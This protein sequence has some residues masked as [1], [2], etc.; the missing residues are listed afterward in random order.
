MVTGWC[1]E[2]GLYDSLLFL[3][4]A[5]WLS[6]WSSR[7]RVC[8]C[9]EVNMWFNHQSDD[10]FFGWRSY[11]SWLIIPVWDSG[12]GGREKFPWRCSIW[13]NCLLFVSHF[14]GQWWWMKAV[15]NARP[16]LWWSIVKVK[17]LWLAMLW[18]TQNTLAVM[19]FA[20]LTGKKMSSFDYWL[21]KPVIFICSRTCQPEWTQ[22]IRGDCLNRSAL[23]LSNV[24]PWQLYS[25]WDCSLCHWQRLV[26]SHFCQKDWISNHC[27]HLIMVR[28]V[29]SVR[30]TP[31]II[32]P[33]CVAGNSLLIPD[34]AGCNSWFCC[35]SNSN[36]IIRNVCSTY[37]SWKNIIEIFR[38]IISSDWILI[39]LL[40]FTNY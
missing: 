36:Q 26:S 9:H 19:C 32:L 30:G 4:G 15:Q 29:A 39:C 5:H 6:V 33:D 8:S 11:S 21:W 37:L 28:G 22:A 17:C 31:V 16:F 34:G 12:R 2:G 35:D 13:S 18:L 24:T 7:S 23:H 3:V 38:T 25:I 1:L 14:A 27:F 20:P 40:L 10:I